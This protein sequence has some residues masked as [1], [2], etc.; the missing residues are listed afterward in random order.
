MRTA[1]ISFLFLLISI[2]VNAQYLTEDKPAGNLNNNANWKSKIFF[3]GN[4]GLSLGT[5]TYIEIAPT[6]G[7]KLTERFDAGFGISYL[8]Y[9]ETIQYQNNA[10]NIKSWEYKSQTY[11]GKLFADYVLLDHLEEMLHINISSLIAHSEFERLN[12]NAYTYDNFG[13]TIDNGR[14]WITSVLVGGGIK[15]NLGKHS[16]ISLLVLYNLTEEVFT[17]YSNPVFK[18]NFTF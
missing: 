7:Y 17:P 13:N 18:I 1:I 11:G 16:A 12:V 5:V 4:F 9:K 2:S 14:T 8:Y 3:G 15:Q 6:I 10:G